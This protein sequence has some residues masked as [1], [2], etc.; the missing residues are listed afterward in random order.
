[1]K[2]S[3]KKLL[4]ELHEI[5]KLEP[6]IKGLEENLEK[7]RNGE[8]EATKKQIAA[9]DSRLK[10]LMSQRDDPAVLRVVSSD[11][12][13]DVINNGIYLKRIDNLD[14]EIDP[15][16]DKVIVMSGLAWKAILN[17]EAKGEV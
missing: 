15:D 2:K 6:R 4:E 7:A 1:M 8:I 10:V 3:I 11:D 16:Q 5:Q 9:G 12:S 17:N 14:S 13:Y